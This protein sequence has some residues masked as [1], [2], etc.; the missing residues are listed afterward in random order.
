MLDDFIEAKRGKRCGKMEIDWS[1]L[2]KVTRPYGTQT[3]ATY[4]TMQ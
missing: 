1:T 2:V 3:Q 4:M